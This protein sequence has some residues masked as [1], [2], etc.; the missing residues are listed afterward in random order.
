[1]AEL[2]GRNRWKLVG[3][4]QLV[5]Q[6]WSEFAGIGWTLV[7]R[8]R[9]KLVVI[10]RSESVGNWTESEVVVEIGQNRLE[11]VEMGRN[12]SNWSES[13]ENGRNRL[14]VGRNQ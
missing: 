6:N 1:M 12:R 7:G 14:V 10:S 4:G 11:L 8:N 2:V 5:G 13:V 3:I 9:P